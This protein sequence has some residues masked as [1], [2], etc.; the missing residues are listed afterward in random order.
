MG[1]AALDALQEVRGFL[2]EGLGFRTGEV[3]LQLGQ[4][5]PDAFL[6]DAGFPPFP[7][8]TP[9][10]FVVL[11]KTFRSPQDRAAQSSGHM[12]MLSEIGAHEQLIHSMGNEDQAAVG[13]SPQHPVIVSGEGVAVAML[14]QHFTGDQGG[15][16]F[17]VQVGCDPGGATD[18]ITFLQGDVQ[19]GEGRGST[20]GEVLGG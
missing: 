5:A 3:R 6:P 20:G 18:W 10:G 16:G 4:L 2:L 19:F 8:E 17:G 15:E 1:A 9:P 11:A 13:C 7:R 14:Q 12:G